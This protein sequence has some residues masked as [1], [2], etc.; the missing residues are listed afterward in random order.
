LFVSQNPQYDETSDFDFKF[1]E[2]ATLAPSG[3]RGD[4]D[5]EDE[6]EQDQIDVFHCQFYNKKYYPK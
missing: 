1:L 5:E 3:L 2:N 4:E 6:E